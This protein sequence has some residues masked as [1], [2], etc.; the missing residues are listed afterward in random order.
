MSRDLVAFLNA[1]YD[2][3]EAVA[4][5]GDD[6]SPD[7]TLRL[8]D[9]LRWVSITPARVLAEVAAKREVIRLAER[10]GD[11]HETVLNGFAAAME[12][13]L[14]LFALPFAD[15]PDYQERWRP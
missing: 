11:Y 4:R 5:G 15:H 1:R 3:D 8:D 14:R 7:V 6:R 10:A 2:E 12:G 9:D 13:A